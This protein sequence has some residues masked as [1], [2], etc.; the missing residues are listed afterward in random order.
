MVS[1]TISCVEKASRMVS[2]FSMFLSKCSQSSLNLQVDH[3][4][5]DCLKEP[6]D[7]HSIIRDT[8]LLWMQ[9]HTK[10]QVSHIVDHSI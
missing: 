1:K 2:S 10:W 5:I 7:Y 3:M 6:E 4:Q 8:E 9:K